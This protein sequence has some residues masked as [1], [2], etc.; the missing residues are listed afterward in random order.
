MPYQNIDGEGHDEAGDEQVGHREGHDEEVGDVLKDLLP[1][2]A[3]YHEHVAEDDHDAQLRE[4]VR[5]CRTI[6]VF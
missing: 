4:A 1:R 5:I 6:Y 3:Q 2:D